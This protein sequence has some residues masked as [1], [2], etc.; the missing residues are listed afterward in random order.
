MLVDLRE[1]LRWHWR[2]GS[3]EVDELREKIY[4][5]LEQGLRPLDRQLES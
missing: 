4:G 3:W 5:D 1:L 2:L